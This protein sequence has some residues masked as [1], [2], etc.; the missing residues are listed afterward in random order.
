[1]AL[2]FPKEEIKILL[3]EN[4]H[5]SA[6]E[7]FKMNGFEVERLPG[8]MSERDLLV[9]AQDIHILGIRSKTQIPAP[10]FESAKKLLSVGCFCIGTNQVDLDAAKKSGVP[11]FNAPFSNTRSVAEMIMA[12]IIMLSRR[13]G[14]RNMELHR[15][16]WKKDSKNC[17]EVR[18]KTIGIVGYGNI[19][20]QVGVLAESLGLKVLFF[21]VLTKMP[22]GNSRAVDSLESLLRAS[23]FVSLHV[24]ENSSTRGMI[25]RDTLKHFKKSSYLLNASRGSIVDLKAVAE[26]LKSGHLAGCAIDVYPE[27]PLANTEGFQT[28]LQ[29]F[30]NVILTPHIGGST[31]EAQENIGKEVSDFLIRFVNRGETTLSVNFPHVDLADRKESHRILNIHQ[32]VPGVLANINAIISALGANI[33]GQQLSTDSEIGYL[34]MDIDKNL[35]NQVKDEI[36]KLSTSIKTRIL[37]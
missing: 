7:N 33:Q 8:S 2:A 9:R 12:E 13:L 28:E 23:D 36:S 15:G 32:N 20:T 31:E 11:V 29:D 30:S 10:F 34:I 6:L 18:G 1:M 27:E 25:N 24:P 22:I 14:D 35:S 16:H 4:V 19:G 17:F 26:Y 5:D 3:L 21:D 37:Y